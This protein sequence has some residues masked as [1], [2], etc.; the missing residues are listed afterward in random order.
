MS[1]AMN[2]SLTFSQA[3]PAAPNAC[4]SRT[5]SA[6]T[7]VLLSH[8]A[9]THFNICF[10]HCDFWRFTFWR[11]H[12]YSCAKFWIL[13]IHG[14]WIWKSCAALRLDCEWLPLLRRW[15]RR[16][17]RWRLW[18]VQ[19]FWKCFYNFCINSCRH[20]LLRPGKWMNFEWQLYKRHVGAYI[21]VYV[22]MCWY[23]CRASE[24]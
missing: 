4:P 22:Y 20:N 7:P 23:C 8:V 18:K 17:K 11:F 21:L 6:T 5:L 24:Y 2:W 15:R 3:F 16:W 9:S 13:C 12:V 1:S 19:T 10:R 14:R